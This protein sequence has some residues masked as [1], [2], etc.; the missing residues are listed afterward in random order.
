M[1]LCLAIA[2]RVT[3]QFAIRQTGDGQ[4]LCIFLVRGSLVSGAV[5]EKA[6]MDLKV[7]CEA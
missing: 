5:Q 1:F 4:K 3:N 6:A 7:V 2:L